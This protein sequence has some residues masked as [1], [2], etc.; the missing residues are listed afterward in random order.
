M[1]DGSCVCC[2]RPSAGALCWLCIRTS[3]EPPLGGAPELGAEVA[4]RGQRGR[5]RM[6]FRLGGRDRVR[7]A[8]DGYEQHI[9]VASLDRPRDESQMSLF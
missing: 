7:V 1:T 4:Y 6:R 8:F 3:T 5:V 2:G 9:D